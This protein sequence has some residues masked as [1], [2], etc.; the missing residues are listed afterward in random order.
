M[1]EVE[2]SKYDSTSK[3]DKVSPLLTHNVPWRCVTLFLLP[4]EE[5]GMADVEIG[6]AADTKTYEQGAERRDYYKCPPKDP[7]NPHTCRRL[8]GQC[9]WNSAETVGQIHS[10]VDAHPQ[11]LNI[12]LPRFTAYD[13]ADV[14]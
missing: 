1:L 8:S 14:L 5:L 6:V 7:T 11:N 2:F 4:P 9:G 12:L 13:S 10:K 3:Y